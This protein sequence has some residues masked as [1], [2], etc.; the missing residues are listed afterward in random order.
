[1]DHIKWTGQEYERY[2]NQYILILSDQPNML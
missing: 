1:M 2:E